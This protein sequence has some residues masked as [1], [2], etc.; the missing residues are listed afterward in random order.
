MIWNTSKLQ[1]SPVEMVGVTTGSVDLNHSVHVFIDPD[2]SRLTFRYATVNSRI[3]A[4]LTYVE[5][6]ME[7]R[8]ASQVASHFSFILNGSDVPDDAVSIGWQRKK[9]YKQLCLV[10]DFYYTS[11]FGYRDF[12]THQVVPWS[13][14][15]STVFW[16]GA[17][18]GVLDLDMSRLGSLPRYRLCR[19]SS[20]L[21]MKADFA[22]YSVVQARSDDESTLISQHLEDLDILR[23][24]TPIEKYADYKYII[25]IDGNANSWGLVCKLR[26][27]CCILMV[28]SQWVNWHDKYLKAWT[29]YVPVR[30]DLSDLAEKILWSINHDD[31]SFAIADRARKLALSIDYERELAETFETIQQYSLRTTRPNPRPL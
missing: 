24:F 18:T 25:Q 7:R 26:L 6:L 1:I 16:R 22:F 17:T 15:K 14:R 19:M 10:P 13:E 3:N 29:H 28:E 23:E 8:Q 2:Q 21:G 11:A 30:A 31:E 9:D 5:N 27:G 12:L 20:K 4:C